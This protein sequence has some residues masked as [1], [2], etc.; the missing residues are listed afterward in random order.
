MSPEIP[1]ALSADEWATV[2]RTGWYPGHSVAGDLLGVPSNA[3]DIAHAGMAL[4]NERFPDG[5]PRK[6]TAADVDALREAVADP[7]MWSGSDLDPA[8]RALAAKLAAL[9]R[10]PT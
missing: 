1:S 3:L 6:I 8:L 2:Q 9:L 10:P 4:A 7:E 5:D